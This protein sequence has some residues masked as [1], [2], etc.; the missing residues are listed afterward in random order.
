VQQVNFFDELPRE[1]TLAFSARQ[2]LRI[3][4]WTGALMLLVFA[5]IFGSGFGLDDEVSDVKRQKQKA[6]QRVDA[7]EETRRAQ[8]VDAELEARLQRLEQE[9][10]FRQQLLASVD[11]DAGTVAAGFSEH[12]NGLGRQVID[13]LWFTE[14]ELYGAGK[15][16][17]LSGT[18]LEPEYLPRYLKKLSA[19][20]VFSGHQFQVL[21][22]TAPEDSLGA[23]DFEVRTQPGEEAL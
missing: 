23:M 15:Q 8:L 12:L 4:A 2:Q 22:L 18:T 20:R 9:V 3:C 5:G 19:E 10:A 16:M 13:G 21:R 14:I 7:L 1:E 17:V 11:P 6:Q